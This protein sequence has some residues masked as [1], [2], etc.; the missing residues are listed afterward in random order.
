MVDSGENI[1]VEFDYNNIS[2]IDPNKVI[3][4]DGKV[5]ERLVK[6]EDLVVYANLECKVIPRTKLAVGVAN[7]DQIQTISV[8]AINFLNPGNKGF[9]DNSYTDEITGK[10]SLKGKGQNQIKQES[11]TNPN[12]SD[13]TYIRQ[14]LR[15]TTDNGMLGIT[16]ITIRQG[17]DFLPQINV[18]LED[19]KGRSLFEGGD[20][21]PYAAFFNLPYPMFNLTIKG[22]YGKA[23]KLSLMLQNFTSRYDTYSGN[24]VVDLVF[25]TYKYTI[26][27]EITMGALLAVPHMYKSRIS[28]QNK[29]V[30]PSTG[31]ET[32]TTKTTDSVVERG[33]QKVKEMYSEYKSKGMISDDFPEISLME[34]QN[35]LENFVKNVLDSF[36][37]QNLDPLTDLNEYS[38]ILG[39]YDKDIFAM[40][41]ESWRSKYLNTDEFLIMDNFEKTKVYTFKKEYTPAKKKD[42]AINKLKE[43]ITSYT[44]KLAN[45][46]TL[47]ILGKYKINNT[48]KSIQIPNSIKYGI[49]P[50]TLQAGD[51]NLKET[52]RQRKKLDVEPSE[53]QLKDF[54]AELTKDSVLNSLVIKNDAGK[55]TPVNDYFVF[56]GNG[57]FEDFI[58]KMGKDLKTYRE[59]IENE[60]TEALSELLQNKDNGIGFIPSIRNVLAVIFANGEAFLRLMDDVHTQAWNVRDDKDRKKS[61]LTG[62]SSDNLTSGNNATEPV[63][64]WP[65]MIVETM[66]PDKQEQFIITYPGDRTVINQTKAY[67]PELWPEVEFVEEFIKG[68][69]QRSDNPLPS[70][71]NSNELSDVKRISLSAIEF[72]VSNVVFSNKEEIKYMYEIYERIFLTSYY[73]KLS[74]CNNF[75]SESNQISDIV[76][77]G[78][79]INII[80][81]LSTDNP[82]ITKKLTEYGINASNFE[83]LL[84]HISNDGIGE[85]WQNYIRG[86]FNTSYIKNLVN[87][88]NF[89]F[90][91]LGILNDSSSQP[92]V[93]LSNEKALS[94]YI[95][96]STTTNDF[97]F[98]DTYPFTDLTWCNT[99]LA[100][101]EILIDA[102]SSFDTRKV[103][104]Y[105][106]NKK[107]ISNFLDTK[108]DDTKRP[109]TNFSYK[110]IQQ[111]VLNNPDLKTFYNNRDFKSQLLTEGN[112]NY[113]NYDGLVTSYQTVSM[114]NTPYFINSIQEGVKNFR[115]DSVTPYV[116]SAYLFINS[117]P[118]STLKE[119][120]K[121]YENNSEKPLDYIFASLKKFGAIHKMPYAWVLKFGSVYHR[122]KNY[123]ENGVDIINTSWS[124]FKYVDNYDPTTKDPTKPY[125][126]TINNSN[127]DIVLEKNS[128]L[129]LETSTLI[130]TGFYPKLINDFNVFYQGFEIYSAYTST[131]IQNGFSSGVTLNYVKDAIIDMGKGFDEKNVNRNLR[132]IPW[133]VSINTFDG[134]FSYILP[135]QGSL[136][137]QTK[138]E[139]VTSNNKLKYEISGNTAM[140][141]G[142]VRLFWTAPNYGYFD[143][144]KVVKPSPLQYLK[145]VF[146]GQTLQ[147]NFSIN[148]I[149]ND[150]TSIDE[151]FSVFEK[152]ILDGFE[153]EFLK[154]SKSMYDFEDNSSY[155]LSNSSNISIGDFETDTEKSFKNFQML[156]ISLM[157]TTKLEGTTP[158]D[159]IIK[160]QQEQL[161]TVSNIL[162]KFINTD[163]IFKY[164]NPSNF[165]KKLFYSF[166]T[167]QISDPYT[168]EKY[169]LTTP[170]TLPY[171]GGLVTLSY[172]KTNYSTQWK[173][174][175]TYVGFSDINKLKYG[176]NG[177]Y[178]TDF[179]I[180]LNIAFNV[181]NIKNLAPIIKIY[182][183]QKL[184]DPTITTS[185]FTMLMDEYITSSETFKG[186]VINNLMP[187]LQTK[188]PKILTSSQQTIDSVLEGPATKVELWES[189]KA[190]ND[191]WISGNDFKTKTLFEDI[192]L[193]DRASR[194]VGDKILVD[195][196]KLKNDIA[197]INPKTSMLVFVQ[198]ILVENNFVVMNL[199]SYVNFYNV[200]DAVKNPKPRAEGS[201][202]FAN[203]MFGTFLNVDYRNSSSKLVCFYGGKP[204][205]QLDLKDNIDYRFRSDAFDLRRAS[206]NP[207]VE[208]QINK[209]DW[210]MSNK[211]VGF[212]VDIGTQNQSIFHGFQVDQRGSTATAESLELLNQMANQSGNRKASTQNVSLFNLYKTRSYNCTVNMMGNAMIQPTMYFNL[213]YVP[214]F[215]GPY[216]ITS[217]NHVISPGSFETIVEG[218]RQPIASL[219]KISAYIQSLKTTLLTTIVNKVKE[220]KVPK[221]SDGKVKKGD[222]ISQ[223]NDALDKGLDN[224][225]TIV[226]SQQTCSASTKYNTYKVGTPNK[227]VINYKNIIQIIN[228]NTT[229]IKLRYIVFATMY[230]QSSN[231][232][233]L[234]SYEHNYA[235]ID[236]SE[237]W[238]D[239][240][241]GFFS[242]SKYYYCSPKEIPYVYFDSANNHVKMLISRFKD[243]SSVF[244]KTN[245]V[246]IAKF[247]I[248]YFNANS[249]NQ[250]VYDSI[251]TTDSVRLKNIEFQIGESILVYNGTTNR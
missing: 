187:K 22:Y 47:G 223:R 68:F 239:G 44:E 72:P 198:T 130:N 166:S 222:I 111:P 229:D 69:V 14:T 182:A 243:K 152:N 62:V 2:I 24:F 97:D 7:N 34:L 21:S 195:V 88:S 219:P 96:D 54:Q 201:L 86:I 20:N 146:S 139:C 51:I 248:L 246:D 32:K 238:G 231:S 193:I 58:D 59:Q 214:M 161:T 27:S 121:T 37:K 39:E 232:Q 28:I 91:N 118:L 43:Y 251:K 156:M 176:N 36:T 124:D 6:Q 60:L 203:T 101:G 87:N 49:F 38:K 113:A 169:S 99:K 145:E 48:E 75:I 31:T 71:P 83:I 143:N 164:G 10:D 103:L 200:Q 94:N 197:T 67:L 141:N 185:T 211:V 108:N 3:D 160:Q 244:G 11:V 116:S 55:L 234:E 106:V 144:S 173:T 133:S 151:I 127:I 171:N 174:L 105:N 12:K 250:N 136:I 9:L 216:M 147:Q 230:L 17:L 137:N 162:S 167:Y 165:N 128:T 123:V 120:Y 126:L 206:D 224:D 217:V 228:A 245:D 209:K 74:R 148:G 8:A 102:K 56:E 247:Y 202:E 93:S 158:T 77:E 100:D 227:T 186:K 225:A 149:S 73:S 35:R 45:N 29:S 52:Y 85:S 168:W 204:S 92:L 242:N 237:F 155:T 192:M 112:L 63:Y 89:E 104:T 205:E 157:K 207:L 142:S 215:S 23:V 13:D 16:Q 4:S 1:L 140:Y 53:Q 183:T 81:S 129:G 117:L 191:K 90:I 153:Y 208:S 159:I 220:D 15:G 199:P 170:N 131:D 40:N 33:F 66:T 19:V 210:G 188:L 109:F 134:K 135:S 5:S 132:V 184:N 181:D 125:S 57:A 172:S 119:K 122:Y 25:Y 70:T 80:N 221:K 110:N 190:I 213:R 84:R 163:V 61:I 50:K 249:N 240:S 30:T 233:G 107:V 226:S 138:N 189:F 26:L 79:S 64:P 65:Q 95:S 42:E 98:G 154:F 46:K 218:V 78:E 236:I 115:N 175:E 76:S 241:S 235:G 196:I 178:I 177:S 82:F 212:N 150:Y 180:D 194:D 41:G 179:F 18:K 114:F